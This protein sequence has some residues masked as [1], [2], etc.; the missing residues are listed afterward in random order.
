MFATYDW[1]TSYLNNLAAVTPDDVQRVA[2]TYFLPQNR[3]VGVY[4][5][6]GLEG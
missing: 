3:T 5:P 1:F 4:I 2:Q 6:D